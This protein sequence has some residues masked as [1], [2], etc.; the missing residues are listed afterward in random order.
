MTAQFV[1]EDWRCECGNTTMSSGF[2]P[3]LRDG[4]VVEPFADQW[5][6]GD[7]YR[8]M[9]CDRIIEYDAVDDEG[10]IVGWAVPVAV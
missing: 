9:Q 7:L 2:D 8:C 5:T 4:T 6:E 3:C 10:W 1:G